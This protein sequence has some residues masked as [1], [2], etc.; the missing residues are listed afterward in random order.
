MQKINLQKDLFAAMK[1]KNTTK[2]DFLRYVLAQIKNKEIDL[3]KELTKE[4][5]IQ[6]LRKIKAQL[7]DS[8][9]FAQKSKRQD[10]IDKI[11]QQINYLNQYL[12]KELS[13]EHLKKEIEKIIEKNKE[14]YKKN[15][16]ALIGI[17][18]KNFQNYADPKT[19]ALIFKKWFV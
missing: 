2:V 16:M 11:N 14:I 4:E 10:L 6:V 1:Q 12:P 13:E 18:V 8:L 7:L 5:I 15:K 17:C 19:I 3:Q 9:S